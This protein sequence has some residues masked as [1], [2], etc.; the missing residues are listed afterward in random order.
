MQ[1]KNISDPTKNQGKIRPG[2]PSD[3]QITELGETHINQAYEDHDFSGIIGTDSNFTYGAERVDKKEE[4]DEY[5]LD[6]EVK[7]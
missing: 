6:A 3:P 5:H 7:K 2:P 1:K 4:D